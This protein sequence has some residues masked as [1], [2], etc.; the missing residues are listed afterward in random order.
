MESLFRP[1]LS[2]IFHVC[3]RILCRFGYQT[4][5]KI[6]GKK[7]WGG[8]GEANLSGE[9]NLI[10]C[11]TVGLLIKTSYLLMVSSIIYQIFLT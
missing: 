1:P 5:T 6:W 3:Y 8:R 9:A 2:F 11:F 4:I 7:G 10:V